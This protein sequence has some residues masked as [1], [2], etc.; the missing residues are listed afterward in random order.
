MS[1][2]TLQS[3]K[4]RSDG[5]TSIFALYGSVQVWLKMQKHHQWFAKVA[6][7]SHTFHFG[8]VMGDRVLEVWGSR[9]REG[10]QV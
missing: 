2:N 7:V 5:D 3:R 1:K 9:V 4:S 6:R 10:S 8:D